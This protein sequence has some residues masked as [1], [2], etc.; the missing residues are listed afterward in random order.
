M[1]QQKPDLSKKT[2]GPILL[3]GQDDVENIMQKQPSYKKRHRLRLEDKGTIG[4]SISTFLPAVCVAA[5]VVFVFK[6]LLLHGYVPSASMEPALKTGEYIIANRLAYKPGQRPKR[7]DVVVFYHTSN[8]TEL[9]VKRVIGLP[10]DKIKLADGKVYINGCLLDE[11]EYA[12]GKTT[13][14]IEGRDTFEVPENNVLVLGDNRESS[15]D[16]RY[17]ENPYLPV[18]D[19]I[20]QVTHVY[21]LPFG[22]AAP[23][24]ISPVERCDFI[25]S[26]P[27]LPASSAAPKTPNA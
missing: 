10:G 26:T 8:Q 11:S 1:N 25:F 3:T 24:W 16:A 2:E 4:K 21:A 7:G 13:A 12:I 14:L 20:G 9:M 27:G 17:W 5:L 23:R 15:A 6:V 18:S 19:I 22:K